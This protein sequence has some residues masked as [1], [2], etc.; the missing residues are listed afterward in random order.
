MICHKPWGVYK[1]I[2]IQTYMCQSTSTQFGIVRNAE[3][4]RLTACWWQ[5]VRGDVGIFCSKYQ[6][7][8]LQLGYRCKPVG[9]IVFIFDCFILII[10]ITVIM[11]NATHT[12][13]S[14]VLSFVWICESFRWLLAAQRCVSAPQSLR[15]ALQAW[16]PSQTGVDAARC[17]L[18]SLTK[19]AALRGL[20]TTTKGWSVIMAMTWPWPGAYAE[21]RKQWMLGGKKSQRR[22]GEKLHL[23][24]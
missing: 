16:A 6:E 14:R 7:T 11:E 22:G 5:A 4:G 2:E 9:F 10:I 3:I 17:V 18:H 24:Y 1:I 20:A 15:S 13:T 12:Y 8:S 21:V 19:I 23:K